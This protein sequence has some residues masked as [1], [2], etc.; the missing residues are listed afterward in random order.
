MEKDTDAGEVPASVLPLRGLERGGYRVAR[1]MMNA[2]MEREERI[3]AKVTM[4]RIV[5]G[6]E[7]GCGVWR[8]LRRRAKGAWREEVLRMPLE[9]EMV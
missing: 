3:E 2:R 6:E 9:R 1:R 8:L 5:E 4:R 7:G